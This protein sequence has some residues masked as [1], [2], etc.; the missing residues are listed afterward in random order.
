MWTLRLVIENIDLRQAESRSDNTKEEIME[1]NVREDAIIDLG[2][3]SE[4]TK[5]GVEQVLDIS[6]T[7][8]KQSGIADD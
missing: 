5:G 3:A 6:G 4:E 1:K 8:Q 7:L 2:A